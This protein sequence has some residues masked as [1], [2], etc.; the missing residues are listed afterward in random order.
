MSYSLLKT[1]GIVE[2][3]EEL[4]ED[5]GCRKIKDLCRVEGETLELSCLEAAK[6]LDAFVDHFDIM[7]KRSSNLFIQPLNRKMKQV[8]ALKIDNIYPLIWQPVFEHCQKLLND[9]ATH[10]ITL[11]TVDRHLKP[12][13]TTLE[14][15]VTNLAIGMHKCLTATPAC[16]TLQDALSK[17]NDYWMI[18]EY[19]DGAQVFLCLQEVLQLTGDFT[20]IE[21]FAS[22]VRMYLL[23]CVILHV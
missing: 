8:L 12:H 11:A 5:F 20:L 1:S 2:L 3:K 18:C 19:Q 6:P 16:T 23:Y 21:K 15:D 10:Q 17:V 22:S 9:L 14:R 13:A 7:F 4:E